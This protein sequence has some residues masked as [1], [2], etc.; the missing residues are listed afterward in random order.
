MDTQTTE[1]QAASPQRDTALLSVA[2]AALLGGMFAFYYF[3]TQ[4]NALIRV[5][6]LLGGLLVALGVAYQTAAGRSLWG[7]V[8]GSRIELRKVVWP[9]RQESVQATLMI[10]VVVLI[11]ALLLWGLDSLLL[12][13]VETLTG[14]GA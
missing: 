1:Q 12:W 3:E 11:M 9:T 2:V 8:V 7:Y 14:R 13:G 6:M 10:A 4:Y 5:L